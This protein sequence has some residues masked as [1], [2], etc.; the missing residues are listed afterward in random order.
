MSPRAAW[1]L[2]ELGFTEVYDYVP[3]KADWFAAGLPREGKAAETPWTGD[4]T[5]DDVPTCAPSERLGDV[6]ERVLASGYDLCLVLNEHQIVLG[7][8]RGDA[9]SKD[10]SAKVRDVMELGPTTQRP[11]IP[12]ED[13]L[14]SPANQG[15]KSWV[16]TT[17]HGVLLGVLLR[18]D[19]ERAL[20][21]GGSG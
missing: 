19:A 2:E 6:R 20:G 18:A 12:I 7:L 5:R 10:P 17:L 14:R 15:A 13:L 4:L 11:D 8:L 3:S 9:L 1:R 16:V 21:T